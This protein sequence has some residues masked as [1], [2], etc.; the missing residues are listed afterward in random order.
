M[1]TDRADREPRI[2][3]SPPT[4]PSSR[5]RRRPAAAASASSGSAGRDARDVARRAARGAT[6]A[7]EP[8]HATLA[9]D[10]R[11]DGGARSIRSSLTFFP[12]PHSYTGEDVVEISAH[13][14]PVLLRAIVDAAMAAGARLARA[15]RVHAA[16]VPER[17]DR[18]RAGRSGRAI[19]I[20]A[21]TPLQARAAFDQLEGTLTARIGDDRRGAVR[22]DRAARGVAR[23]SGRGLSL[24]RARRARA[25]E[26][27]GDRRAGST[28]L[29]ARRARAGA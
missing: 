15:G 16:R 21:V 28:T 8:R 1:A 6:S 13:G 3:C 12:A 29:L 9:R 19:S 4:T 22:S 24:R 25:A 2:R 14:S 23:F 10:R 26:I 18:S 27:D 7:L 17:P 11:A 5:S 20:D